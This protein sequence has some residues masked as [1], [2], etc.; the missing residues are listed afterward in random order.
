MHSRALGKMPGIYQYLLAILSMACRVRYF[1][2]RA[3]LAL[4]DVGFSQHGLPLSC[5]AITV[6]AVVVHLV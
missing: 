4:Y 5:A 2:P 6:A 1:N 3:L